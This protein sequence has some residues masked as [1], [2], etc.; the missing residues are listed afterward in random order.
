M[1]SD[2]D[3]LRPRNLVAGWL[4]A[5]FSMP[6]TLLLAAVGQGLGASLG[7]CAWIGV[8]IPIEHPVW[9]L[10]NE[11][12]IHFA[13]LGRADGYWLGSLI[14]PLLLA[15][16]AT[17]LLP[18]ARTVASE[19]AVTHLA[20]A[21]AVVGLGW[22]PLI[23]PGGG[24]IG[25][26]LHFRGL[27][28]WGVWAAPVLAVV[29]TVLVTLR[30]LT[31]SR[32]ANQ[33]A[34]AG[35]RLLAVVL[36][37]W[38]PVIAWLALAGAIRGSVPASAGAGVLVPC[39]L[40]AA[41]ALRAYPEACVHRLEPV[42]ADTLVRAAIAPAVMLVIFWF[43]GR[44]LPGGRDAGILWGPPLATNN[45]RGWIEPVRLGGRHG[46]TMELDSSE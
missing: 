12:D 7:G 41:L 9:A 39:L 15:Y 16:T 6:F 38:L 1:P 21:S 30:L 11:P 35:T 36:H 26:W 40:A 18:R 4:F 25:G 8:S 46:G 42:R 14:L 23:D 33:V 31:L 19:L 3:P 44:P 20:W 27:P 37:L 43:A 34:G 22:L 17:H 29:P 45:I 10:V 13:S 32:T 2:S 28:A 5:A 24:H